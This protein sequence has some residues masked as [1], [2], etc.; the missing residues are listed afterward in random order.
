MALT[1]RTFA[2][3][4][5][6]STSSRTKKGAGWKLRHQRDVCMWM[7]APVDCKEQCKGSYGALATTKLIHVAEAL[8]RG[9]CVVLDAVEI[10]LLRL[11]ALVRLQSVS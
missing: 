4:S 6:A 3:S 7:C 8:K 9:H 2:L 10:G 11:L 1:L 5:A